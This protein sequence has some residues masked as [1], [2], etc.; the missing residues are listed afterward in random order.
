MIECPFSSREREENAHYSRFPRKRLSF[1]E[2]ITAGFVQ[3]LKGKKSPL[4]PPR[5]LCSAHYLVLFWKAYGDPRVLHQSSYTNKAFHIH[6][7]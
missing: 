4:S 3:Y 2:K 6:D 5:S 7:E 1:L